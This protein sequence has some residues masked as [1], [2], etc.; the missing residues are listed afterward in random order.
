MK[1][2]S[3]PRTTDVIFETRDMYPFRVFGGVDN[4]GAPSTDEN[5]F[6]AG[7]SYG[8]L[9][10]LDHEII[11][12][13]G[14][15][16]S[17]TDFN[18][19]NLQY[20]IP[21]DW[22]HKLGL[23]ASLSS[24]KP[25]TNNPLFNVEGQNLILNADYEIPL[26]DWGLRGFTQSVNFG[27]DYK[28]LE[29][30]VEFGGTNVF[31]SE[32]EIV[33]GYAT[34]KGSRASSK[35]NNSVTLT[36][37]VSPGDVL[38]NNSD[39]DFDIARVGAKSSYAYGRGQYE[40]SYTSDLAGL[41]LSGIFRGQYSPDKLL[42]TEQANVAGPGAVRG[43]ASNTVRRDSV[44]V[45]TAEAASPYT[46]L[47]DNF[48]GTTLRDRVQGFVFLDKGYGRNADETGAQRTI[49]LDSMGLGTR[50]G[51]GRNLNG[52]VEFGK[53]IKDEMRDGKDEHLHFRL[54]A[55]Y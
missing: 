29:N 10:G 47:I 30:D 17:N 2:G 33:Q 41:T 26:Y 51:I 43:F 45:A 39:E 37:I 12:S 6:Y 32:P 3:R 52:V 15:S 13:F 38:G 48:L 21:F 19:H 36:G 31:N 40:T 8:N 9:F 50:F 16:F 5:Q 1:P 27:V 42:A 4:Y 23:S 44:L 55:A 7:F 22:R 18:S 53:E 11:Y 35:T 25:D 28:R 20:N 14:S 24:S 34:Y 54:N 46:S 49:D